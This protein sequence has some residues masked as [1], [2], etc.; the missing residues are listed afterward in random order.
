MSLE[1]DHRRNSIFHFNDTEGGNGIAMQSRAFGN[2][3]LVLAHCYTNRKRQEKK[4][5][6]LPG[7]SLLPVMFAEV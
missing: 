6:W 5:F 4:G 1:F 3:L 2:G 7:F